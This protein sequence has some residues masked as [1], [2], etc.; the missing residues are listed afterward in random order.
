MIHDNSRVRRAYGA[1]MCAL[2]AH[3]VDEVCGPHV[4]TLLNRLVRLFERYSASLIVKNF[5][6]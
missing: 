6:N 5:G 2:N 1:S 4:V 3:L